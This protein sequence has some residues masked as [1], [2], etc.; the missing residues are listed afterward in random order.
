QIL[1]PIVQA[2]YILVSQ[3]MIILQNIVLIQ[4]M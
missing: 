2:T 3:K 1:S 4:M